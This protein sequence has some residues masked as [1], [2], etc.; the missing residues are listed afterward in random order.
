MKRKILKMVA[1]SLVLTL[2]FSFSSVM[3]AAG[4]EKLSSTGECGKNVNYSF[5]D[6]TGELRIYGNGEMYN[7]DMKF[8]YYSKEQKMPYINE[9]MTM[10]KIFYKHQKEIIKFFVLGTGL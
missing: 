9:Q 6:E 5:N 1:T 10:A 8:F 7:Y 3:F 2:I 4:A